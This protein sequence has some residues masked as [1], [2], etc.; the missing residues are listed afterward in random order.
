MPPH[1]HGLGKALQPVFVV[2]PRLHLLSDMLEDIPNLMLYL[3]LVLNVLHLPDGDEILYL[4]EQPLV[5][6]G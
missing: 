4:P 5:G 1:Q 2:T 3:K 6:F